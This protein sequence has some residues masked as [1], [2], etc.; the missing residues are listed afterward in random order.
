MGAGT[1]VVLSQYLGAGFKEQSK[2]VTTISIT[3]NLMIGLVISFIMVVFNGELLSF[4]HL[5][6][7]ISDLGEQYLSIVG[8][9][10]FIQAVLQTVSSVL[11]ANGFTRDAMFVS[12]IMNIIHLAGNSILIF[13]LLGLPEMGVT[14]VVISTAISRS[15]ALI[16]IFW[17]MYNRFI[18]KYTA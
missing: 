8:G 18:T 13:G 7:H 3:H 17:F 2:T 15:L 4:F 14:G 10:I 16:L 5:P 12:I 11:R 6:A 9:T 1:V